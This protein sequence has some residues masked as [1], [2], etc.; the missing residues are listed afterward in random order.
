MNVIRTLLVLWLATMSGA[1]F[2][3]GYPEKPVRIIAP[4]PP[5]GNVDIHARVI[6][7]GLTEIFGQ[8]VIVDNRGGAGGMIGAEAAAKAPPDGYTLLLGS[9]GS[10]SIGP[11]L[12]SKAAYESLRDFAPISLLSISPM[13]FAVHP[14][15]PAKNVK[16]LIALLKARPGK[17]TMA[18]AGTGTSNHLTGE[19]FQGLTGTKMVHVPYKGSGPALVDVL[20]GQV[21]LIVDQVASS[22]PHIRAGKLRPIAVTTDKRAAVMPDVPTF[23]EAGLKG[24][25]ANTYAGLLAPAGTPKDVLAKLNAA[26]LRVLGTNA[27][28][29]RFAHMGARSPP[30]TRPG[31]SQLS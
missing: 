9:N 16:E 10:V 4:F 25:E 18:T 1:A 22:I 2:A 7:A 13:T 27:T 12:Y 8:T 31:S 14:S 29:E 5:G 17:V 26:T 19:L 21:D 20:G 28:K 11:L 23:D 30:A 3:Q 15:T 24:Y 6:A